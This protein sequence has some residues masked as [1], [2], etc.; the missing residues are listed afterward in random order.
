MAGDLSQVQGQALANSG[1]PLASGVGSLAA[2]R[3]SNAEVDRGHLEANMAA[4]LLLQSPQEYRRWL[5][6]YVRHLAGVA[7]AP[8]SAG[9]VQCSH[10]CVHVRNVV[11]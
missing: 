5:L 6:T 11:I 8:L 1:S 3:S 10:D 4:A 7:P 2:G 9:Y